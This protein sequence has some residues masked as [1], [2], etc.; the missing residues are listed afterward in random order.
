MMVMTV[1]RYLRYP[2][3]LQA[4][5]LAVFLTVM[6]DLKSFTMQWA[7]ITIGDTADYGSRQIESF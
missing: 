4:I 5:F 7:P 2:K 3:M 1:M 6:M